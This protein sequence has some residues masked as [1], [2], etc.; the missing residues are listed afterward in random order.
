VRISYLAGWNHRRLEAEREDK[1][2]HRL[3]E[4]PVARN[5]GERKVA[6]TDEENTDRYEKQ[7][8]MSFETVKTL[9]TI[10]ISRMPTRLIPV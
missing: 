9:L 4:R 8:G 6:A 7:Q 1:K 3:R 10:V 5:L 2:H